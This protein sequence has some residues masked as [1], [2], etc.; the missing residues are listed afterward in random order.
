MERLYGS[1]ED[2]FREQLAEAWSFYRHLETQRFQYIALFFTVFGTGVG[3]VVNLLTTKD[4]PIGP[5]S[6]FGV[7]VVLA[8]LFC[9]SIVIYIIIVRV[10][11]VL[12][13]YS[14][15]M[16]RTRR[17]F[18]GD[19]GYAP[20]T[21]AYD[22]TIGLHPEKPRLFGIQRAVTSLVSFLAASIVVADLIVTALLIQQL[23]M[24][25]WR[26]KI[27]LIAG[28]AML[29]ALPVLLFLAKRERLHHSEAREKRNI[30]HPI[31]E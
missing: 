29:V 17:Y 19:E 15:V 5:G 14:D 4:R 28:V 23:S 22:T 7:S 3:F 12:D 26:S 13:F 11:I 27:D 9:F 18:L 8:L 31:D 16:V 25:A 6:L 24:H 30:A 1:Q 20:K 2:S 21:W 10:N